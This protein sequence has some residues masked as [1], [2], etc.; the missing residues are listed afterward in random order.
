M[1]TLRLVLG[2]QLHIG[3]SWFSEAQEDVLYVMMEIRSE[4]DYAHHHI[5]KIVAFFAAMRAFSK[6]LKEQGHNV[7]YIELDAPENQQTITGNIN[8][9]IKEHAATRFEY[10]L[11]DEYR[12]DQELKT[13]CQHIDIDSSAVESEHFL[14]T[15]N[16]L[17]DFFKGKKTYLMDSFYRNM[18]KTYDILMEGDKPVT[19]RW[20]YDAENRKKLKQKDNIVSPKLFSKDVSE[21]VDLIEA[22]GIK[23]I[24]RINRVA[25]IWPTTR[26]E[27]LELLDF[28]VEQC[29]PSFGRFQDA[30]TDR[31]WS[32]YHSRLSFSINVKL[33]HPLEVV[34]RVVESWQGGREDVDLAQVEGFVRQII[35]WREYMRGVYWAHMPSYA[36][37]NTLSHTTPLPSFYW[38]ANTKM[39]CMKQAI[40]QSL[41]HAYA[42]HIQRLM[43]T[44][45]FALLLGCD[46]DEVDA[47][48]LGIYIDALEWVEI[49]N[50][51][52]MSQFADGGIVGTKPYV[53]SANYINKMS[54]HCKGCQYDH[55]ARHGAKSCPFNALYWEFFIRHREAFAHNPR[56]GM[57]YRHIDKMSDDEQ[58]AIVE[59]AAYIREH[60]DTL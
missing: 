42:H 44:G 8:T 22:E 59:R 28:F 47:W 19:G 56:I 53:S 6:A 35:G 13:L 18:R 23:T 55:K 48:Y 31:G 10:M 3:H 43:V 39:A 4:T 34:E 1:T 50:T 40:H 32:L 38:D 7:H 14:T 15:R 45:N 46:P 2:D 41:E 58:Q 37:M 25:F 17:K 33:L 51:R 12:V 26:E 36:K 24:G 27:S 49:T 52:G 16:E 9:L 29:L 30:M 20:N 57:A 54:D 5:Q 11:P 60:R 21:L